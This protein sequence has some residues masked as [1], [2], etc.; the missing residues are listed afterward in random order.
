M[1]LVFDV[2]A[3]VSVD[4]T[5]TASPTPRLIVNIMG[6]MPGKIDNT[7]SLD[8]KIADSA[9]INTADGRNTTV[10]VELPLMLE[11]EDYK[12]FTLPSDPAN[13]KPF[14]VVVDINKPLPPPTF[15]FTKGLD[16]K[17]IAIDP[18]HGGSDPGAIGVARSQEKTANLA[19]ALRV[20][21]LL[22][23]AGAKVV[24]THS[25][26]TDVY[27][28]N[29]SDVNEL[30]ARTTSANV[31]KADIFLSIHSNSFVNRTVGG[32]STYYYQKTKYDAML[33][34]NIQAA[35]AQNVGL[36]DRGYLPANYYVIK[37]TQMPAAL[38]EM[39]FISNPDEEKLLNDPVFQEKV[40]Q[41]IV[42]GMERFFAQAAQAG[43][44][45]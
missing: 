25:T 28:P 26:D 3:P 10:V 22:E 17:V 18:G 6:A 35:V 31:N 15:N 2:S 40:A 27:G 5:V 38:L 8:G 19:V 43:G 37:R 30:K 12:V 4:G 1:R 33:A 34:R 42:Q 9:G 44:D 20:K 32:T 29:A 11:E 41:G 23:K 21:A 24:M 14:R 7:I 45:R 36:Q 16:D 13:G 39:A